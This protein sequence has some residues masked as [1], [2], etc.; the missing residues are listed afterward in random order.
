MDLQ[1][2]LVRSELELHIFQIL[3]S[4][5]LGFTSV[6]ATTFLEKKRGM[7]KKDENIIKS[8]KINIDWISKSREH[9]GLFQPN[10]ADRP[11]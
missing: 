11:P 8:K 1:V 2:I 4:R 6:S 5:N 3:N 10:F 9:T 7:V